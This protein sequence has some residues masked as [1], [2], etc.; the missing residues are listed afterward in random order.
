VTID[1][2]GIGLN[3]GEVVVG[4]I[5]SQ[6]HKEYTIIGDNVNL[7]ARIVAIALVNQV[8]ISE[9]TYK[10]L[11]PLVEVKKQ[12]TVKLKGKSNPV[13]IYEIVRLKDEV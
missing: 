3:T 7:T 10:L 9:N 12:E 1:G 4:N 6:K 5:G 2:I 8:L 13:N 11:A